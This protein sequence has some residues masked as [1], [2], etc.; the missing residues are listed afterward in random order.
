M[1]AKDARIPP[2]AP[3]R[4]RK[5]RRR[6]RRGAAGIARRGRQGETVA[7]TDMPLKTCNDK[8]TVAIGDNPV[9]SAVSSAATC[10]STT[11][12]PGQPRRP[13]NAYAATRCRSTRLPRCSRHPSH[14]T[15]VALSASKLYLFD[16]WFFLQ[17]DARAKCRSA[18]N[19]I[20]QGR[21]FAADVRK[22]AGRRLQCIRRCGSLRLAWDDVACFEGIP[23]R[24]I[25]RQGPIVDRVEKPLSAAEAGDGMRSTRFSP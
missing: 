6:R 23:L 4:S 16:T 5:R 22:T 25:S 21:R 7:E 20:G 17:R 10:L 15:C 14:H 1:S 11:R 2:R 24:E 13:R 12:L 3:V 18:E 19:G 8:I 9:V